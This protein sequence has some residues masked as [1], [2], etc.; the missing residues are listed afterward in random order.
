MGTK[1][2]AQI[3]GWVFVALV[4]FSWFVQ[5]EAYLAYVDRG[6]LGSAIGFVALLPLLLLEHVVFAAALAGLAVIAARRIAG[7]IAFAV[8]IAAYGGFLVANQLVYKLFFAPIHWSQSEGASGLGGAWDSMLAELDVW[9]AIN[10]GVLVLLVAGVVL[11][12][13]GRAPAVDWAAIARRT[14]VRIAAAVW[15]VAAIVLPRVTETHA[16]HRHPLVSLI[17]SAV[18]TTTAYRGHGVD[19][20]D[21]LRFGAA[22]PD[23]HR[24]LEAVREA[25]SRGRPHVVLIVLES[26]GAVELL[27][28]G[29]PDASVTPRLSAL[30]ASAVVLD[31]VYV[32]FPSTTRTHLPLLTGGRTITHGSVDHD[33]LVPYRGPT[34]VGALRELDYT[35]ALVSAQRLDYERLDALY[36]AQPFDHRTS[37]ETMPADLRDRD[38]VHSWGANEEV[39]WHLARAWIDARAKDRPFFLELVTNSTH[40]PY[41]APGTSGERRAAY[42]EALRYTDRVIG[43][44]VD[45]LAM[46]GLAEDTLIAITGDHGEAFGDRHPKNFGHKNRLYE[47]NVRSFLLLARPGVAGPI[48]LHRTARIDDVMPTLL[49]R[50]HAPPQDVP[51]QDLLA[52]GYQPRIAYFHKSA[53]PPQWGLRDGR[54]KFISSIDGSRPE[55][56]DLIADPTE[57]RDVASAHPEQVRTYLD[58]CASWF[59]RTNDDFVGHTDAKTS[60]AKLTQADLA[61]PGPKVTRFAIRIGDRDEVTARFARTDE[62]VALTTWSPFAEPRTMRVTWR[63]PDGTLSGSD[64]FVEAGMTSSRIPN[65]APRPLQVGT[66]TLVVADDRAVRHRATF[67][68]D[69]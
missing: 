41:G 14:S 16:L 6:S 11:V 47:E 5:A 56:Y 15:L 12:M 7:R 33:M 69:P 68:V 45:D 58:L 20:L 50:V 46:R 62:I 65:L 3:A 59:V 43:E 37:Y 61:E 8:T 54:W 18:T 19:D 31:H 36:A 49:A 9:C 24:S 48:V 21:R 63:A 30:A 32:S 53:V 44:L 38:R 35:T 1:G 42:L 23:D 17:G 27:P 22:V 60:R 4:G 51:G 29:L 34:L 10:L 55:L 66:W 25:L 57:Q 2:R 28:D 26:V 67:Q 64:L 39:T 52:P 40:H 13:A